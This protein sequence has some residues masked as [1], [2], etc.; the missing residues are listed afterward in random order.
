MGDVVTNDDAERYRPR[1]SLEAQLDL[2]LNGFHGEGGLPEA[3]V[4]PPDWNR[5]DKDNVDYFEYLYRD[6]HILVRDA[7]VARVTERF[8]GEPV[9]GKSNLRGLTLLKL[10]EQE[11]SIDEVCAILDDEFGEG[12]ATPDHIFYVCSTGT[13]PATEPDPVPGNSAPDPDV[14]T[15]PCD[16]HGVF[17]AVLDSGLVEDVAAQSSWL[18]GVTGD[19]DPIDPAGI[20]PYAGHGTFVAGALRTQAP[21]ATVE[22]RRT[23][24]KVGAQY[25]SDLVKQFSDELKKGAD[26][27]SLDFGTN[28]RSDIASLGFDVVGEQLRHH[29]GVVLVAAAG[30]DHSRRPFWPAAFCWAVGVGALSANYRHRAHFSNYG[31]WVDVYAPGEGLVNAYANGEYY[32]TEPPKLGQQAHFDGMCQWSGTSFSTPLVAGMIAARMSG[33]GESAPQATRSLLAL[34]R[35]Q[36]IRGVGPVLLPGQACDDGPGSCCGGGGS[37]CGD[38]GGPSGPG[39]CCEHSGHQHGHHHRH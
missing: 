10:A 34:A 17:V 9:R 2:I 14:E 30:N 1:T 8:P 25:E 31:R 5:H 29:P 24:E 37:C 36:A 11:R 7:D 3:A 15:G 27:I 13:C 23:F 38:G 39:H 16:G 21:R 33:T 4:W 35:R 22:V 32:Y 19:A 18:A 6:H 26:I 28:T 20:A 12:I